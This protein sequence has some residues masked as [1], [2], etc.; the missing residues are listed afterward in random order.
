MIEHVEYEILNF[1][2]RRKR[3]VSLRYIVANV[4]GYGERLI[5]S[6]L[7]TLAMKDMIEVIAGEG[8]VKYVLATKGFMAWDD[9]LFG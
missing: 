4:P 6:W 9:Y 7:I 2:V 5:K 8:D 3:Q 1:L